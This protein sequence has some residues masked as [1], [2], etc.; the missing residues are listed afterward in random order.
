VGKILALKIH[1]KMSSVLASESRRVRKKL[2]AGDRREKQTQLLSSARLR[3]LL[4][5]VQEKAGNTVLEAPDPIGKKK[6]TET[7]GEGGN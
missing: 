6:Q 4:L 7:R 2:N 1:Y 5:N 3:R